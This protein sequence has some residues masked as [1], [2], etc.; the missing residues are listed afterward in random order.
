MNR[1]CPELNS[2]CR[3]AGTPEC[4]LTVHHQYWPR[5]DYKK[6]VEKQFRELAVNKEM[7]PRCDHDELHAT[8]RPPEKPT[9]DEM[10][11]VISRTAIGEVA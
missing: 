3:Y 2:E 10:L 6:P 8:T 4:R 1:R 7:L 9:R 5:R 11:V